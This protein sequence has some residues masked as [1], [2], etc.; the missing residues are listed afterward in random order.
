MEMCSGL[1]YMKNCDLNDGRM[2]QRSYYNLFT[3]MYL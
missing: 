1:K 3:N 2:W